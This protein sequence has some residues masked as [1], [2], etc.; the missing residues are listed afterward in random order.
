[1]NADVSGRNTLFD[2]ILDAEGLLRL[3]WARGASITEE[4]AESA[5]ER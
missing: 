3:T 1:M 2:L 5:M 4:D